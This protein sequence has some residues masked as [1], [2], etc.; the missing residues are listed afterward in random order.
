MCLG[1]T[2]A[3]SGACAGLLA[4]ILLGRSIPADAALAGFTAGFATFPDLDVCGSGPARVL[5][6]VSESLAWVIGKLSGGHRHL[7]H[8]I[9]GVGI[10][11]GLAILAAHFRSD[12][13]GRAGL[14]LLLTVGFSAG[15]WGLR[16]AQGARGDFLALAGT[17]AVTWLGVGLVLVPLA[18][19]IG[20]AVHITGD[21]CTDSGCRLAYPFSD[22]R[23]H[24]LPEPLAFT[25]GTKP[26]LWLVDP[27][28]MVLL[29]LLSWHAV[30]LSLHLS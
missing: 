24:L 1:H 8:S 7:T 13:G 15:L 10:F 12:I 22:R 28:L 16:I 6:P 25:T 5:G 18:V 17:A 23:F 21:L 11:T 3:A 26:E 29:G 20:C 2:H 30:T 4:G 14:M 27:A 19:A 9:A